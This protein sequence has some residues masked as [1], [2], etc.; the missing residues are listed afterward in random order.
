MKI[1]RINLKLLSTLQREGRISNQALAER[2]DLS[3]SACLER[4]RK[5]EQAGVVR[6]Y[7][8]EVDLKKVCSTITVFTSVTLHDHRQEQMTQFER[9]VR[10]LPEVV[11]CHQVSG[12][13]DYLLRVVCRDMPHYQ[14]VS[15][16]LT[17]AGQGMIELSSHVVMEESKA[18]SGFP[19]M[20][21][22]AI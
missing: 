9:A 8:A 7:R 16:T 21:L 14:T 18:F 10:A 22:T 2:V 19:L 6:G 3:P 15:N 20:E 1:D 12:D 4:R 13:F 11:E 5:L 17:E